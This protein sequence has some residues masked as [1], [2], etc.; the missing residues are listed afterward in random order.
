MANVS[1]TNRYDQM[2]DRATTEMAEITAR[3]EADAAGA[4]QKRQEY[5]AA[6][7]AAAKAGLEPPFPED[8][9]LTPDPAE[10]PYTPP[11][12]SVRPRA[13]ARPAPVA[14]PDPAPPTEAR[15]VSAAMPNIRPKWCE[16]HMEAWL[17]GTGGMTPRRWAHTYGSVPRSCGRARSR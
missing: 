3:I 9:G 4:S 17:A 2:S 5:Q 10:P 15:H 7:D 14:D 1:Q 6:C 12:K 16:F 11:E 13:T 8:F